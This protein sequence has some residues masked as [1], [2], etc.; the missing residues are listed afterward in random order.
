MRLAWLLASGC[1]L[2]T[3]SSP[4]APQPDIYPLDCLRT[5]DDGAA[6]GFEQDAVVASSACTGSS[7]MHY[8]YDQ[9]LESIEDYSSAVPGVF[10]RVLVADIDG[11]P[12]IDIVGL[13]DGESSYTAYTSSLLMPQAQHVAYERAWSDLAIADLDGDGQ[14][15]VIVAG[16]GA[17]RV[18]L[19]KPG[20]LTAEVAASDEHELLNGKPFEAVAVVEVAGKPALFYATPGELG[21]ATSTGPLTYA[22]AQTWP[23]AAGPAL[24]LVIADVDGDGRPDVIGATSQL[25][26]WSSASGNVSSLAEGALAIAAGDVGEGIAEPIFLA[27]DGKSV[28]RAIV[29]ADGSLSSEPLLDA[30]GGALAVGDFDANGR[31]DVALVQ[32]SLGHAGTA[33]AVYRF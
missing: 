28:R 30:G 24:P 10:R 12:P 9:P 17:I 13:V 33:L 14:P 21:L 7:W 6:L 2:Y 27:A 25:F 8:V 32:G 19:G 23:A 4:P 5:A 29:A 26:V 3:N 31:A 20:A 11:A 16:D 18:T 1:S 22:I 15:D